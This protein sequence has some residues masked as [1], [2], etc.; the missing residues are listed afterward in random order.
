MKLK[1]FALLVLMISGCGGSDNNENEAEINLAGI[2]TG[3]VDINGVQSSGPIVALISTGNNLAIVGNPGGA[4]EIQRQSAVHQISLNISQ[5]SN[6]IYQSQLNDL[7]QLNT[8]EAVVDEQGIAADWSNATAIIPPSSSTTYERVLL[9]LTKSETSSSTAL[10]DLVGNWSASISDGADGQLTQTITLDAQG[11]ITGSDTNGCV[12]LGSI[13]NNDADT[14]FPF[15]ITLSSCD[16]F[17]GSYSGLMAIISIGSDNQL[18]LFASNDA[19]G[20]AG[21]LSQ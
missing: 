3:F 8:I 21:V 16:P 15:N 17:N 18:H 7:L 12:Y 20:F 13:T 2:Y 9:R 5:G 14:V 19:N 10:A 1:A 4:G 6:F 11:Q